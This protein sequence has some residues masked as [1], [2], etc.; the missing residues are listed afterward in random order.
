MPSPFTEVEY[1]KY[2]R[3]NKEKRWSLVVAMAT[4]LL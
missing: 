3:K 1:K 2:E 4:C